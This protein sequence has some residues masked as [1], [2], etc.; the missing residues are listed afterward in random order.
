MQ[1]YPKDN[2]NEVALEY[3][4][5]KYGEEFEYYAPFGDSMTGTHQLLV[6][7]DSFPDQSILVSIKNYRKD[8]RVFLDNYLAVKYH[9]DTERLLKEW[10]EQVFTEANVFFDVTDQPLP[11]ELPVNATLEEFLSDTTVPLTFLVEVDKDHFTSKDQ[12]RQLIELISEYESRYYLS[13][14]VVENDEF[15]AENSQVL[16]DKMYRGD[17][18]HCAKVSKV[19]DEVRIRWLEEE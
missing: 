16:D 19:T 9:D 8:D 6:K 11:A 18:I 14:L 13:V 15:G 4:Q 3:M 7:C 2:I 1:R 10:A 12:I 17:Y 5:Q